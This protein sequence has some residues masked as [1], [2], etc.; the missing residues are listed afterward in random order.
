M[1]GSSHSPGTGPVGQH[2]SRPHEFQMTRRVLGAAFTL[3]AA[4]ASSGLSVAAPTDSPASTQVAVAQVG[5]LADQLLDHL[6]E[7][8]AYT[9]LLSGLP[10][11]RF[12]DLSPEAAGREARFCRH[13]LAQLNRI[14]LAKL[15]HEQWLLARML[16]HDFESGV[17]ADS[18]YWLSF[19]VTPYSAGFLGSGVQQ[20]LAAQS[21]ANAADRARYLRLL[22]AYA[23]LLGQVEARTRAQAARGIRVPKGA[24]AGVRATFGT[25][26]SSAPESF[27]IVPARVAGAATAERRA[28]EDEINRRVAQRIVPGY[29]RILAI[30]DADYEALA[31]EAVGIRQYPG[32]DANYLRRIRYETGLALGPQAIHAQGL[33]EVAALEQKMQSIRD[34]LGFSG[35]RAAF[36]ELLHRDPRFLAQTPAEVEDRYLGHIRRIEPL[37]PAFFSRLPDAPYGVQRLDPAAEPGMTFGYYQEAT[38]DHPTGL[39]RYNGSN[40]SQRSL[41]T[42]A[43][44]IYHELIPGHHFQLALQTENKDLH[45][46]RQFLHYGAFEEGWAEYAAELAQEMGAL[47]D[48]YD[49]YGHLLSQVFLATRLVVDTGMNYLGWSLEQGRQYMREHVFESDAQIATEI[50]RYSTDL[51]AQAL[52]YRIGYQ[53]FRNLRSRAQQALGSQFDI[54]A[55]HAAAIGSGAMPLDVL[56][57]HID[58][59]IAQA[60]IG[61]HD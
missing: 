52:D 20:I 24:L 25:L 21:L 23:V 2:V 55:F 6:R 30:V 56:A 11:S 14:P 35:G 18:D 38:P 5:A 19:A 8:S 42:S 15:P 40:L 53:Q 54:R 46:V 50:L 22:D 51:F 59:Y 29:E 60:R 49:R 13:A 7:T 10:I 28:F 34:R 32:G 36:Q 44:L 1:S 12:D 31:P 26:K 39:Y 57:E 61:H 45:P 16:R 58:W 48:P 33:A 43:H 27:R 4:L 9:R 3:C 47:D 41:V 17:D 37:V